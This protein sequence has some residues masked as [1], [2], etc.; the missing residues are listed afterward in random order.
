MSV[1]YSELERH[2]R[3]AIRPELAN[4][5][6]ACTAPYRRNNQT[7]WEGDVVYYALCVLGSS[8]RYYSNALWN[9]LIICMVLI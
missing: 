5:P 3:D 9:V 6:I 4:A 7:K 8:Y 1:R 2:S